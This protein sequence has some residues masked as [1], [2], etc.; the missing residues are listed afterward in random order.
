MLL[1]WGLSRH[2]A[3][4]TRERWYVRSWFVLQFVCLSVCTEVQLQ[5]YA[6][7]II[8]V[9]TSYQCVQLLRCPLVASVC[10]SCLWSAVHQ[11]HTG[12]VKHA[13]CMKLLCFALHLL[14]I[15]SCIQS[16]LAPQSHYF[17]VLTCSNVDFTF[18]FVVLQEIHA[19]WK[20]MKL[21]SK[22]SSLAV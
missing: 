5:L 22:I 1:F 8:C 18:F 9:R 19:C 13:Q 6:V 7:L 12:K 3:R 17:K 21:K 10:L 15:S 2:T 4:L 14:Y 16:R 20:Y 11:R